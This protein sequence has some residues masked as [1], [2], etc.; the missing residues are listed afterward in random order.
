MIHWSPTMGQQ[1]NV[2][3]DEIENLVWAFQYL[4]SLDYVQPERVGMGGFSV[5]ASFATVAAADPRINQDVLFV[6][7]LGGYFDAEDLFVQIASGA[8]LTGP[9][10][11]SQGVE[12]LETEP[13]EVNALTRRVFNNELLETVEDPDQRAALAQRFAAGPVAPS[14]DALPELTGS[15]P[16]VK[17]LLEG[18]TPENAQGLLSEMPPDFIAGLQRISPSVHVDGLRARLLIMHDVGDSLIPV[19]ESR[20]FAAAVDDRE[21]VL[22]TETSIF[23]HVRP[24]KG[25]NWLH[26]VGDA[27]KLYRHMYQLIRVAH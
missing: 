7:A 17:V 26:L 18:T 10:A 11:A 14:G 13:W 4:P 16:V 25:R 20:R 1:A 15:A 22:Y 24:G 5:G 3:S 27:I 8:T 6:N 2:D 21:N 19:G 23:D 12:P 9:G